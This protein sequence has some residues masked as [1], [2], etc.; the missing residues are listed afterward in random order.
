MEELKPVPPKANPESQVEPPKPAV[1]QVRVARIRAPEVCKLLCK[2]GFMELF[3]CKWQ[4]RQQH[5]FPPKL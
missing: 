1:Q 4:G 3:S 5:F 2:F